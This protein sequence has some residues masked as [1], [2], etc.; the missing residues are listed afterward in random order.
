MDNKIMPE[1]PQ[2]S[3]NI[4]IRVYDSNVAPTHAATKTTRPKREYRTHNTTRSVYHETVIG[5]LNGASADLEVDA[6][7]LGNSTKDTAN[8]AAGSPLGNET[9]RTTTT[10]TFVSGQVFTAAVFLDSTE[11]NGLVFEE[12]AL[13]IEQSNNDL[14]LNRFLLDDPGGLLSPKSSSETVTVDIEIRQEDA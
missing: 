6:L 9:F 13:V 1:R 5:A 4:L 12:A 3:D 7:A 11:G 14:P 2:T 8:I 10:D